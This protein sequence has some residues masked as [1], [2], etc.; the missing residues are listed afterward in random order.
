MRTKPLASLLSAAGSPER[1]G[2]LCIPTAQDKGGGWREP[3]A[4]GRDTGDFCDQV[5]GACGCG[6]RSGGEHGEGTGSCPR[7]SGQ[8]L[9]DPVEEFAVRDMTG[10]NCFLPVVRV[11]IEL[12]HCTRKG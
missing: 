5:L 11:G 12:S 10:Y 1:T 3:R 2:S 4:P 6:L 7:G 9:G 8:K